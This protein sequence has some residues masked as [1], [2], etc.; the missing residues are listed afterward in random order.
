AIKCAKLLR[1]NKEI[2]HSLELE[3]A[4]LPGAIGT[5]LKEEKRNDI[6]AIAAQ[7]CKMDGIFFAGAGPNWATA[8]E[9]SLKIVETT[10]TFSAGFNLEEVLHGPRVLLDSR[11]AMVVIEPGGQCLQRAAEIARGIGELGTMMVIVTP[12]QVEE[13]FGT[14]Q[15]IIHMPYGLSEHLTP[16]LYIV[17]LQL[18]AYFM[19]VK[20]KLNPDVLREDEDY[21]RSSR[22]ASTRLF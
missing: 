10:R 17:P 22:I 8:L 18:L 21:L 9:G 1:R 12:Q 19:A 3:L 11:K 13:S 7:C 5:F 15:H 16:I 2:A 20:K 4:K 6:R 14:I